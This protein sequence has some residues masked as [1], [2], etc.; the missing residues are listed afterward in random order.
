MRHRVV[1]AACGACAFERRAGRQ[2]AALQG[3]Q[4]ARRYLVAVSACA[5]LDAETGN[6][7]DSSHGLGML[8]DPNSED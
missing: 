8:C 3:G 7:F 5:Q 2:D 1:A 4:D 6:G